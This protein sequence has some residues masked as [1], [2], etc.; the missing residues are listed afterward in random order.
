MLRKSEKYV[1]TQHARNFIR[2]SSN[3]KKY[4]YPEVLSLSLTNYCDL[5]CPYCYKNSSPDNNVQLTTFD[6]MKILDLFKGQYPFQVILGGGEPF[7]CDELFRIAELLK[8]VGCKVSVTTNGTLLLNSEIDDLQIFDAISLSIHQVNYMALQAISKLIE[9]KEL[10]GTQISIQGIDPSELLSLECIFPNLDHIIV[11]KFRPV[12]RGQN[13]N[14]PYE[15]EYNDLILSEFPQDKLLVTNDLSKYPQR[16]SFVHIHEDMTIAPTSFEKGE[17]LSKYDDILDYIKEKD[18]YI[19]G[20]LFQDFIQVNHSV[21]VTLYK[22][23]VTNLQVALEYIVKNA[24]DHELLKLGNDRYRD[25]LDFVKSVNNEFDINNPKEIRDALLA[26]VYF[27]FENYEYDDD[28]FQAS[29]DFL[30]DFIASL[31]SDLALNP[32]QTIYVPE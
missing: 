30:F 24:K 31:D 20:S 4:V 27:I 17:P 8:S 1:A 18:L 14:P 9:C 6:V 22:P 11:L 13:Y 12:G 32:V 10:N 26:A 5:G 23:N 7:F 15:Y 2:I 19:R 25:A 28:A 21:Y 16:L 29:S 3:E